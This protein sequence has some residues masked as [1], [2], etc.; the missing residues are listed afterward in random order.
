[1][2][3]IESNHVERV[4]RPVPATRELPRGTGLETRSTLPLCTLALWLAVAGAIAASFA[5]LLE[6]RFVFLG[7]GL[8]A[9]VIVLLPVIRDPGYP[10]FSMWSFVALTVIIGVSLRGACL[11]FGFP[12]AD[13][14]DTLFFLGKEPRYFFPAAGWLLLGLFSLALGW[15]VFSF[16]KESEPRPIRYHPGW[17]VVLAL[18]ILAISLVATALYIQRTGGFASGD[19]S[20]KRT[21]IPD[22]ELAGSD[23]QSHG[24]LRFVASLAIFGHL[25][26]L[27]PLLSATTT[28]RNRV[29]LGLLALA[30]LA[31]ACVVPFYASLRTTVAL[32]LVF[33]AAMIHRHAPR[34]VRNGVLILAGVVAL[35]GVWIM[36]ALRPS[37]PHADSESLSRPTLARVFEAAVINRNQIELPKTAHLLESIPETL[38]FQHGKTIAR[39]GLAPIPRSLWADKPVI[40]P[41]PEIGR[42]L[43]DQ[44]VAGVPPSLVGELYWNF[45]LPGVVIGAFGFGVLLHWLQ[46][47]F[48]AGGDVLRTAIYIA[49]PMTLGFEA[50]GSSL[51]SGLFR[52][53]LQ[54]TVMAVL[55][56]C[57]ARFGKR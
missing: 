31:V 45:S 5:T 52:A 7:T 43:Y 26:V 18:G 1:M 9:L 8:W 23:Y 15:M 25:L 27:A 32:H 6:P 37:N 34:R 4:S 14:L 49:G 12:D 39:W 20:A 46:A 53:T 56:G 47:R 33:S 19:W 3:G 48:L 51:G 29:L 30:L 38:P 21:V 41:G 36:T 44:R 54:T 10:L 22:L 50:V 40:P 35:L 57:V 24:G 16:P 17:L 28:P 11:S 42:T 55:V 2:K 13:R